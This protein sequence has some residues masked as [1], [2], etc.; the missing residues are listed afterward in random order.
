MVEDLL[1]EQGVL[2][3]ALH[4]FQEEGREGEFPYFGGGG[5]LLL[6]HLEYG[7]HAVLEGDHGLSLG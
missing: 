5:A 7:R 4:G 6:L 3:D 2:G 1:D